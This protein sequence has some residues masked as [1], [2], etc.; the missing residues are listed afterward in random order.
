MQ[1]FHPQAYS[2]HMPTID[3]LIQGYL[4]ILTCNC[5]RT[6]ALPNPPKMYKMARVTV[7]GVNRFC[8]TRSWRRTALCLAA[9]NGHDTVVDLLLEHGANI[10]VL[11]IKTNL[12]EKWTSGRFHSIN[13]FW[14]TERHPSS[15]RICGENVSD[16]YEQY[17]KELW[18]ALHVATERSHETVV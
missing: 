4:T 7:N 16:Y 12:S 3:I 15:R 11:S 18:T 1:E 14:S 17:S 6:P 5:I 8:R 10:N 13:R 2:R 9:E